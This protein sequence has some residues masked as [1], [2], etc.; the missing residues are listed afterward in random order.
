MGV[1]VIMKKET[2]LK[3]IETIK[4]HRTREEKFLEGLDAVSPETQNDTFLYCE[5]EGLVIDMLEEAMNDDGE[6]IAWWIYDTNFGQEEKF[7]SLFIDDVEVDLSS[8]EKLYDLLLS[9]KK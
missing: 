9:R 3:A 4:E 8:A 2:F 1:K 6:I 7:R 5:Y